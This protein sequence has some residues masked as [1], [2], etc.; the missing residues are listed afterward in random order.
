MRA[1][2]L[3]FAAVFFIFN[4]N[5][6]RGAGSDSPE[7]CFAIAAANGLSAIEVAGGVTKKDNS[8]MY[9]LSIDYRPVSLGL[10]ADE[11]EVWAEPSHTPLLFA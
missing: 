2:F 4:S 11:V 7:Q 3:S 9:T 8:S 6:A 10:V 1:I 5:A